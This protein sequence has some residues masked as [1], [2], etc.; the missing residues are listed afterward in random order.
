MKPDFLR[1]L[2][3]PTCASNLELRAETTSGAEVIV[4]AL[5]CAT[6]HSFPIVG[7]VPRFVSSEQYAGNFGFEWNIH[8]QTQLDTD[9]EHESEEAFRLKTG[10]TPADLAGKLVLDVGCGMGRFSEVASR[11][12]ATVVGI[13]LSRAVDAAYQN[14]GAREN[15]HIAQA[16]VFYLPFSGPTF[17]YIF[18]VGVLHHTPST[19]DAFDQL[20]QLLRPGGR[21]AIWV[22]SG[23]NAVSY[24]ASDVWRKVTTRMPKRVLYAFAHVAVP[25]HHLRR[26]PGLRVVPDVLVPMSGHPKARWRI[27]DT[28][29]WYSPR[30]QWKHT[31]QEVF[32][33]FEDQDLV[34]VRVLDFPVSMQGQRAD[35]DQ[36]AASSPSPKISRRA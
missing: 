29:D 17:D 4:G 27:L 31:Y 16:D 14:I 19:K 32:R 6:G 25:I 9:T 33:W 24:R 12:G 11:W 28:F 18:S 21:I 10:F 15:V 30:Y 3:C 26:V 1:I 13:D 5:V 23:Y 36:K 8:W 22:Y 20:P 2:R 7:G 35:G 34:N